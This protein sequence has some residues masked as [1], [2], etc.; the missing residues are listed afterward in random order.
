MPFDN[1]VVQ[2]APDVADSSHLDAGEQQGLYSYYERYLR[3]GGDA[4]YGRGGTATAN[5]RGA[6][7]DTSGPNTDDAMTRS[8]E[9]LN[10]GTQQVEAGRAR[11]RKHVVTEQQTRQR[12]RLPLGGAGG[13][14]TDHRR[15]P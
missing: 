3:G 12:A 8:E 14:G 13:P 4:A 7:H 2:G 6:G 10:G 9:R 15:Q 5:V 11:L 1:D